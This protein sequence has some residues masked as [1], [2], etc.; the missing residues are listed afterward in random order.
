MNRVKR[1]NP[2]RAARL[3]PVERRHQLLDC[4]LHAFAEAGIN[5][6]TH[7][8][9][10]RLAAVSV[11]TVFVYFPTRDA[12]V[13]AVLV[14]VARFLID[15]VLMPVQTRDARTPELLVQVGLAFSEAVRTHPDHARVWLDWS[16]A[17]RR[18]VWPR[19]VE[20]QARVIE[21]LKALVLRGKRDGSLVATLDADD[22]SRL[23]VGS[24]H[25]LAQMTCMGS[26][27]RQIE[28]FMR[29]AIDGFSVPAVRAAPRRAARRRGRSRFTTR[30]GTGNPPP[31]VSRARAGPR[32]RVRAGPV[33][34]RAANAPVRRPRR[35]AP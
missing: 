5:R 8:D 30:P 21:L 35:P 10:A 33:A 23:L 9:V 3:N 15:D 31:S 27:L 12:L 13:D 2:A 32:C 1:K 20:F 4:A 16:T 34:P 19:Y 6:A 28:R 14:E 7:A 18:D 25:M 17:F 11:P 24:A 26:D 29:T 22:A